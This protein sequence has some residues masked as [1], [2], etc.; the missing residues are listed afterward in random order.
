MTPQLGTIKTAPT[1]VSNL[2]SRGQ[3][4]PGASDVLGEML[5]SLHLRSTVYGP[6]SCRPP[7]GICNS[8]GDI[9]FYMV[10]QGS[11]LLECDHSKLPIDLGEGDLILVTQ[12]RKHRLCDALRST[13]IPID[14][15]VHLSI[16]SN[17]SNSVGECTTLFSGSF[18]FEPSFLCPLLT[19]LPPLIH[20][21]RKKTGPVSWLKDILEIMARESTS[22]CSGSQ[23][24]V[25]HLSHAV[26]VYAV[27]THLGTIAGY[28]NGT[29]S[30]LFDQ[31]IGHALRIIHQHPGKSW[32]VASLAEEVGMSRS[33]FAARFRSSVGQ[34][35]LHYLIEYRMKQ[36]CNLLRNS[37]KGIKEIAA[38]VGYASEAAFSNAFKRWVGTAPGSYRLTCRRP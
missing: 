26:L 16:H 11:C 15:A 28:L 35:P 14:Q 18:S 4:F 31:E 33:V 13:A 3:I 8:S 6:L 5:E 34:P 27:R 37:Q 25:N 23:A 10:I 22:R 17:G 1:Q 21:Q 20:I 24:I 2:L 38:R 36:A 32:T 19:F 30:A 12:K 7:W 29:F 9:Q